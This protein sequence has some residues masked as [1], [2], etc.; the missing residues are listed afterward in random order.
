MRTSKKPRLVDVAR[1][2]G[3]SPATVSR[4]ISQ[5]ELL[6]AATLSRVRLNAQR[7]GF[8]PDAAARA[9][10][11]GRSMTVGAVMPTLDNMI[12]S[13]A[14]QAMQQVLAVEG[15]QLLV[16][17]HNYSAAAEGEAV[18]TLIARGIDGLMLVGAERST[19]TETLLADLRL[20]T[21]LTW[22]APAVASAVTVDNVRAGRL[23]A[24][25]LFA[26]GHRRIGVIIGH[27]VFNDR[28]RMRLDGAASYLTE[29]DC[30]LPSWC[31]IEQPLT[32]SGGRAGCAALT[33]LAEPPTAI[34]GG[35]D[36]LAIGAML[37]AQARGIQVPQQ[38]SVMGI[39]DLDMSA[40]VSPALTTVHVPTAAIGAE[41]ARALV[42]LING[43]ESRVAVELAVDLVVRQSTGRI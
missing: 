4:A 10:A 29:H 24:E 5:P 15:F 13:R 40:H 16:A 30:R 25:H 41:A 1:A 26:L 36:L 20:P 19:E 35:I 34:I 39:D 9:L 32:L 17:S 28:Q 3:V 22:S 23:A 27:L 31:V 43:A 33:Q 11:S 6:S 14:L 8:Q 2:A 7:L 37:E 18:R 38:M 42:R 12:F 21:V